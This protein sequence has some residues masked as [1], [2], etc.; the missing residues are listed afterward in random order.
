MP[1]IKVSELHEIAKSKIPLKFKYI[2]DETT[3][4]KTASRKLNE[5]Y[6]RFDKNITYDIFLSH[7]YDDA[8]VIRGL[9]LKLENNGFSVFVDWQEEGF[10]DRENVDSYRANELRIRMKSCRCLLFVT[11]K[12]SSNSVWM[13][14]ELGFFDGFK[15]RVAI[16]PLNENQFDINEFKGQE[17]LGIYPY[18]KDYSGFLTLFFPDSRMVRLVNWK[19]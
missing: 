19:K 6:N 7:S 2:F 5:D 8:L 14:W 11:S 10:Q 4:E 16:V 18:L 13:P 17:Y 12:N 15:G 3:F 9:Q 1:L